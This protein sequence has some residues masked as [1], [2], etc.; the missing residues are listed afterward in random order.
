MQTLVSN[1][2]KRIRQVYQKAEG[3]IE[4]EREFPMSQVFLNATFQRFVTDN[5]KMLKDLHADLHDDW[6]RL[7]AT[8]DYNGLIITLSVDLKL[9][10]MELNK[11]TQLIV[12]E[13]ISDTQ[14]IEAKYPNVLYKMGVRMALWFYQKVL[15]QDPLGMILEKLNVIK[16]KDDLLY[17]DLNRWLG[18]SRSIIDTLGK[19]HVNHAVLREAELV[20][21]GNVNLTALFTKMSQERIEDWDDSNLKDDEVTP[22]KQKES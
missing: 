22:I 11:Q 15:N 5:V 7:Y 9:V 17:L 12:F 13:Q 3:F 4:D 2:A 16:V 6:L 1:I 21:I 20:V 18:K 14:V 8:L 19:V 10:Q